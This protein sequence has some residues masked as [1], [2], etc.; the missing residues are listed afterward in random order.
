[1]SSDEDIIE[2]LDDI[3]G[4]LARIGQTLREMLDYLRGCHK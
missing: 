3:D 2:K 1:M 4:S